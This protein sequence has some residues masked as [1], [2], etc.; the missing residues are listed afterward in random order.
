M[1]F[2]YLANSEGA[3]DAR[4]TGALPVAVV[5]SPDEQNPAM[6]RKHLRGGL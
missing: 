1:G 6:L 3:S 4:F 5:G 2:T